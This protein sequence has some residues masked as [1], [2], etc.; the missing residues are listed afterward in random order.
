MGSFLVRVI[1]PIPIF[2]YL[3]IEYHVHIEL[4][5]TQPVYCD[6]VQILM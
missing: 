3:L 6:I 4:E 1:K 2:S 5:S